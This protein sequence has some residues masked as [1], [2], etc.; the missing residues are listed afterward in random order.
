MTITK[1]AYYDQFR[2]LA[3]ACPD[4]CCHEWTVALDEETAQFYRTLPGNLGRRLSEVL[5]EEDGDTVFVNENRRCPMWR[6][7]GLCR[8]QAELGHDALCQ[9]C[10]DFPRISHDYGNFMEKQL[11][12]SCP[13]AARLIL[14]SP[15]LPPVTAEIPGD[16]DI[17]YE[18]DTVSLLLHSRETALSLLQENRPIPHRLAA[19]LLYGYHIQSQLDG[20]EAAPFDPEAALDAAKAFAKPSDPWEILNFFN[21]LEILTKRW[22]QRLAQPQDGPWAPETPALARYFVERY[23]LQAVSDYDLISR[24]KLAVLSCLTVKLLGGDVVETAQLYSKEIENDPDNL[25]ALL[26]AAY[27]HPAFTDAKLLGHLFASDRLCND[28]IVHCTDGDVS[29]EFEP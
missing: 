6:T 3:G 24:V 25:D 11:E 22:P 1:P 29:W 17:D 18:E 15:I 13:E 19:L 21:S 4:S 14:R 2:C 20:G 27:S 26:D 23:W 9:T 5:T 12:L 7:D 8:I 10:R 28:V 16:G